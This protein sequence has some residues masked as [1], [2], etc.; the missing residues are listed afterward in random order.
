MPT[1][2]KPFS[3]KT[4]QMVEELA[5]LLLKNEWRLSTAE[6]CTGGLVSAS[7]TQLAGSS[8]WF[9]RGYVTYSN[10]AKSEDIGV[11]SHLIETHGAVSEQVAKAMAIGA[12]QSSNSNMAL[13]ITGIA[14]PTGGSKEKPVGTVCFAWILDNDQVFSETKL[15]SGD[16]S[17]VR[18][19]A[20][21]F[22]IEHLLELLKK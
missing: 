4:E 1:T 22:V 8:N 13:S 16:R 9:E 2:M 11:E 6:S 19:Q 12:K 20:S 21:Q 18:E 17:T 7:L 15:F 5:Q 3:N 10:E 14:G